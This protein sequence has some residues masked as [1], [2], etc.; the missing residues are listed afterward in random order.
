MQRNT[1]ETE[2][3]QYIHNYMSLKNNST[4]K[5]Q[6]KTK[7]LA[8]LLSKQSVSFSPS[9]DL[10]MGKTKSAMEWGFL[11]A[12]NFVNSSEARLA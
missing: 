7:A 8:L 2:K 12:S 4:L 6:S 5:F 3:S 11:F 10:T 9:V 1:R